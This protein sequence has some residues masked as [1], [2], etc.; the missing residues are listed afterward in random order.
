LNFS[1]IK[2]F[3]TLRE[4][5]FQADASG[6][7]RIFYGNPKANSPQYDLEKYFQYLDLNSAQSAGLSQQ[8]NN[9]E[10]VPEKKPLTEQNTLLIPSLL[11]LACL[12]LLA[13]VYKFLKK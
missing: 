2:T 10:F 8:K 7:Y 4:L 9:F 5:I 12:I 11:G 1:E 13:L 6:A 3:A